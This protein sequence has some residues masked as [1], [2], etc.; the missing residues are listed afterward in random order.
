MAADPRDTDPVDQ[1]PRE[2]EMGRRS[3]G[4]SISPWLII[5]AILAIAA[6]VYVISAVF[7]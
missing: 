7:V 6:A 2:S 4:P 3:Y 5:G 1:D